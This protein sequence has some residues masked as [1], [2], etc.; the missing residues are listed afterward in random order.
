MLSFKIQEGGG[1]TVHGVGCG[2]S[3]A[4]RGSRISVNHRR[5]DA[6]IAL[7]NDDL[8]DRDNQIQVINY[9]KVHKEM[10]I[11]STYKNVKTS[12]PILQ[13]VT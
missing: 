2:N 3:F 7:M 6:V 11:K 4:K 9:E 8:Q 5:K 12:S 13:H 10:R 1:Q